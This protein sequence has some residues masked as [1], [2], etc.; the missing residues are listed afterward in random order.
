MIPIAFC[1]PVLA[2]EKMRVSPGVPSISG[3]RLQ[4]TQDQVIKRLGPPRSKR[5]KKYDELI[6]NFGKMVEF[7]FDGLSID[8]VD[9][10][11]P[12]GPFEVIEMRASKPGWVVTP[13]FQVG[14]SEQAARLVLPELERVADSNRPGEFFLH[15]QFPLAKSRDGGWL[16]LLLHA[17][18]VVQIEITSNVD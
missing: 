2:L 10:G 6:N 11:R 7:S 16:R 1:L 5:R 17:G 12:N 8:L 14:M 13:G 9:L 3:V 18:K 4:S 15:Y